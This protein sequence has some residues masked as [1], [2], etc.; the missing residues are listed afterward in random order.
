MQA[1]TE[2]LVHD[3]R[4]PVKIWLDYNMVHVDSEEKLLEV[5]ENFFNTCLQHG[6]F[7]HAAKCNLY[8]TKVRY[9]GRIIPEEGVRCDPRT[10]STLQP[11]GT[12]HN[13]GD[14]AQ[15]VTALNWMS[16]SL[17]LFAERAAPLHDL[18][19]VV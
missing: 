17:K 16:S 2:A 9:C 19:E 18:L 6:L 14:L 1:I 7:H 5:L 15:Y 11:M 10:M 3:I 12:P 8:G 4:H 13:G